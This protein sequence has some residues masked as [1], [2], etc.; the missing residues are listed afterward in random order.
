MN[1]LKD[2][3]VMFQKCLSG[4]INAGVASIAFPSIG[5]GGLKYDQMTVL[6]C[7]QDAI[8]S[9]SSST[10]HRLKVIYLDKEYFRLILLLLFRLNA[11]LNISVNCR[12]QTQA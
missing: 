3:I 6:N 4:A 1:S 9:L 2:L 10:N 12:L 11:Y 7:L 5:A 8:N